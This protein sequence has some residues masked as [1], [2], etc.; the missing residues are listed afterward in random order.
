MPNHRSH[1]VESNSHR[2]YPYPIA[3]VLKKLRGREP[4]SPW[5]I[6]LKN[7]ETVTAASERIGPRNGFG[8]HRKPH[9]P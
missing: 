1:S 5:S 9:G 3:L 2:R 6:M 8:K 7:F 4:N